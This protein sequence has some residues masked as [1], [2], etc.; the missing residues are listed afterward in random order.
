MVE[1]NVKGNLSVHEWKEVILG[2][3]KNESL[4]GKF[5]ASRRNA[6][7]NS[8]KE[9]IHISIIFYFTLGIMKKTVRRGLVRKGDGIQIRFP[10]LKENFFFLDLHPPKIYINIFLYIM[11]C[12]PCGRSWAEIRTREGQSRSRDSHH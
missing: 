4:V 8:D 7:Q 2:T 11:I 9:R 1:K 3:A 12:R 6:K 10:P 5:S